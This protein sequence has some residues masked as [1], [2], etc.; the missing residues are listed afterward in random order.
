MTVALAVLL[1]A[2]PVTRSAQIQ[3]AAA[4]ATL[5]DADGKKLA[6][7]VI[8]QLGGKPRAWVLF[9]HADKKNN[10]DP[11]QKLVDAVR[12]V[13]REIPLV[14]CFTNTGLF[15]FRDKKATTGEVMLVGLAG[16]GMT[17]KTAMAKFSGP[18]G[19]I[20]AGRELAEAL[21]PENG[22]GM[23]VFI[24]DAVIAHDGRYP[25][26]KMYAAIQEGLGPKVGLLGGNAA[27]G[28]KPVYHNDTITTKAIVGLMIS[29]PMNLKIIQE[30]GKVK[31]SQ[32]LTVTRLAKPNEI[33]ELDGK[34]W[35]EAYKEHLKDY[36][37]P[38]DIEA[39][40]AKGGG[41]FGR[42]GGQFPY[43]IVREHGQLYVRL[44]HGL[45]PWGKG[46]NLPSE[47]YNLKVGDK[48]V[49]TKPADD[50]VACIRN[51]MKRLNTGVAAENPSNKL[52]LLFPCQ[53][54]SFLLA[55]RDR[56]TKKNLRKEFFEAVLGGLSE[57]DSAFG[58]MPCGEH[59][60]PYEPDKDEKVGEARYHQLSYP[61]GVIVTE[62]R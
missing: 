13:D 38:E 9:A 40:I 49:L 43:A 7:E 28:N 24:T 42:I 45:S 2:T 8:R 14:G 19:L 37:K 32:E 27:Y 29:G 48:I 36:L 56:R 34:P 35:K 15:A 25:L 59:C 39:A 10:L 3:S 4:V 30:P 62:N 5:A 23:M 21:K 41:G 6:D 53:S 31:I 12:A 17:F 1:A 51:G 33:V 60:S 20:K 11:Q 22:R 52:F 44:V 58:F 61:M 18:G 50:Q 26:Q 54:N 47:F 55:Q 57:G 16:E 46:T